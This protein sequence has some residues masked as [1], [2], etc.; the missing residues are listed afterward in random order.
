MEDMIFMRFHGVFRNQC[1]SV[2]IRKKRLRIEPYS[3]SACTH[4]L[5]VR[6]Q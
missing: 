3:E 2:R 5:L 1:G 4:P 6:K